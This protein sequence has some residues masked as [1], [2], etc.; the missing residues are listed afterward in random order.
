MKTSSLASFAKTAL[1]ASLLSAVSFSAWAQDA[2][3]PAEAAAPADSANTANLNM[4]AEASDPS[5][6]GAMFVK[7]TYD[8]WEQRCIKDEQGKDVCQLYQL[9]KDKDG[10]AVAEFSMF[11]LPAGGE[12]AAGAT[13]VVPL[14]VL[15][16]ENL[17]MAIDGGKAKIY[18]FTFCY[19]DGCVARVGF[20]KAEVDQFRKGAKGTLT[21]VPAALPEEKISVDLSLKGFTAGYDEVSKTNP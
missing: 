17:I 16:T 18:P 5:D 20:T 14:E 9:L 13:V 2:A 4:G 1:V 6:A 3:A 11:N 21:V 10:N 15:L 8:L 7:S 12:A 19:K